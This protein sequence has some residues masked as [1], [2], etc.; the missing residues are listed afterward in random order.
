MA[1]VLS[2]LLISQSTCMIDGLEGPCPCRWLGHQINPSHWDFSLF[3]IMWTNGL[4]R[5]A[6]WED[7]GYTATIAFYSAE[8]CPGGLC[9][10]CLNQGAGICSEPVSADRLLS[11]RLWRMGGCHTIHQAHCITRTLVGL[12]EEHCNEL[13]NNV[14]LWDRCLQP[15]S[16]HGLGSCS[17]H[18]TTQPFRGIEES[19]TGLLTSSALAK[20]QSWQSAI[21]CWWPISTRSQRA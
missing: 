5:S 17:S 18:P 11:G 9:D 20:S 21:A 2:T 4:C 1:V 6:Q 12:A 7:Q 8:K 19:H 3:L 15:T 13:A 14:V 16:V 10:L